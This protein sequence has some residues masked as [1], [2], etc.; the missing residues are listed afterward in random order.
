VFFSALFR[1]LTAG[2]L[3]SILLAWGGI[4]VWAQV[5]Q[6][7]HYQATLTDGA[8]PV[9]GPVDVAAAFYADST[10]GTPL[11]GWTERYEDV[12]LPEGRLSLLLGRTT[13]VPDAVL[14]RPALYLQLSV[15]DIDFPRLPVAST[16]FALRARTA[17]AV[18][19]G[20]VGAPALAAGAVTPDK[21]APGAVGEDAL[22]PAAVTPSALA[23]A[24][25]TTAKVDDAAIT[26]AKLA[27]SAVTS[28]KL[29]PGAVTEEALVNG[30]VTTSK[31]S[32]GAIT[33]EKVATGQLLTRLNGLTDRV[34]LVGGDNV[35]VTTSDQGGTITIDV[36]SRFDFD[37][38]AGEPSSRRW[39]TEVRPLT[40]A[41]ALVQ[42]LRGVRYRWTESG[43]P[44]VGFIAEEVGAVVPEVVTYASNGTDAE[45]VNYARLVALLVEALKEQ[46]AQMA[47]DRAHLQA[48]EARLEALEAAR[49]TP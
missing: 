3:G 23:D 10:G 25:V 33:A 8:F 49:S 34:R 15:N 35:T 41:L 48:L 4:P 16:A 22:A 30:A 45:T 26:S 19:A 44:D 31:L 17:E 14:D 2:F 1:V 36:D 20:G 11:A 40:D 13:P 9:D 32:N 46:Q 28:A 12:P 24:A 27:S 37:A 5:P 7:L 29:G 6:I 39:K 38:A 43:T 47:A 42:Q 21:I 18:V